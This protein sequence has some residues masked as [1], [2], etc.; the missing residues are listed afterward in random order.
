MRGI[1]SLLAIVMALI[2]PVGAL[3]QVVDEY[4]RDEDGGEKVLYRSVYMRDPST[5]EKT[6]VHQ[7]FRVNE[8]GTLTPMESASSDKL[9]EI[10]ERTCREL[11]GKPAS[12]GNVWM[13]RGTVS[14]GACER[15]IS[16]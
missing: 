6:L 2:I 10:H 11:G 5:G 4:V 1:A 7:K 12:S 13:S 8:D 9:K 15:P 3:A 14:G 16:P